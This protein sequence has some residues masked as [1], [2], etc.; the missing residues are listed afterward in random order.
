M[1]NS[2]TQSMA[3]FAALLAN[4]SLPRL[5]T[6]G[7]SSGKVR[8]RIEELMNATAGMTREE[9]FMTAVME[10]GTKSMER[11]GVQSDTAGEKMQK[12]NTMLYNAKVNI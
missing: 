10:E 11:L 7:I 1:G 4:Q 3:D 12:M 9:A 8:E 2:A 5:D 6:F